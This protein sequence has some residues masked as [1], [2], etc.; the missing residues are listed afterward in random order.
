MI[1]IVWSHPD[2]ASLTATIA[3]SLKSQLSII[4]SD[5]QSVDLYRISQGKCFPPI[6]DAPEL[7]R[8]TSFDPLIQKQMKLVEQASAY[9]IIHPDWWGAAPAIMKGWIDRV[10]RPGTAYEIPEGFGYREAIGLLKGRKAVVIVSGDTED[11]GPLKDF[12]V[13]RIWGFCGVEC[14]LFYLSRIAKVGGMK[15]K[16]IIESLERSV[17]DY[18]E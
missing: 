11:A 10:L 16:R 1:L 6:L 8:K 5:I 9:V 4:D 14:R 17:G 7:R 18:L 13:N 2:P 12:W 15:R 3:E